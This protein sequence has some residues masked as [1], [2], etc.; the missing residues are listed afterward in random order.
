MN[1][2]L[3]FKSLVTLHARV[4]FTKLDMLYIELYLRMNFGQYLYVEIKVAHYACYMN[5]VKKV[6]CLGP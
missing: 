6:L 2:A 3:A 1:R 4:K 5:N